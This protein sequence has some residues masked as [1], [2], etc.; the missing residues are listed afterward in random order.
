M[1]IGDSF[2]VY[3]GASQVPRQPASGVVEEISSVVKLATTDAA[4]IYDGSTAIEF[5]ANAVITSEATDQTS[6]PAPGTNFSN[7]AIKITDAV[8]LRKDGTTD[9]LGFSG[10]QVDA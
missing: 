5:T 1:A 4:V 8:Y 10:V 7:L 3:L 2:S 9:T 6:S